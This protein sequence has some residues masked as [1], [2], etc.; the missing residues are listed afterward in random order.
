M[1]IQFEEKRD[2]VYMHS[3]NKKNKGYIMRKIIK[4]LIEYPLKN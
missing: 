1:P 4:N 2:E 3:F